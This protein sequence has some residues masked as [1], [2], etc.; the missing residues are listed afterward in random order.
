MKY[1]KLNKS[2]FRDDEII[3]DSTKKS[4]VFIGDSF[5][6]GNGIDNIEDRYSNVIKNK[7]PAYNVLNFG[8][9][10][11]STRDEIITI[12][13]LNFKPDIIVWQYFFIDFEGIKSFDPEYS[14]KPFSDINRFSENIVSNTFIFNFI[15]WQLPHNYMQEY[16]EQMSTSI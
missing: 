15:Y 3:I 1:I 9:G 11:Q 10:G 4:I 6:A 7:M 5:T 2:G 16:F 14:L 12:K 13:K 8:V